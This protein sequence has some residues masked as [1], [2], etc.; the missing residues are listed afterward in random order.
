MKKLFSLILVAAM[1]LTL[2]ACTK[3][4]EQPAQEPAEP[5]VTV[6]PE[7]EPSAEPAPAI[8]GMANPMTE[9]G[10]LDEINSFCGT[11]LCHPPVMGVIDEQFFTISG[12]EHPVAQYTF[13]LNGLKYTF[14]A[15]ATVSEDISGVYGTDGTVFD[16]DFPGETEFAASGTMKLARW[17]NINGQYVL[18]LDDPE[19]VMDQ[20]TFEMVVDE[21]S[22]LTAG[23]P[24]ESENAAYFA[25]LEGFYVDTTS[26]RATAEISG[27]SADGAVITVHWG[28]SAFECTEWTMT[29]SRS[30]DG[31]LIYKD[32][33]CNNIE[34]ATDGTQTI[35]EVYADG[36]GFF[37]ENSGILYWNGAADENCVDCVFEKSE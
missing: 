20:E 34:T 25:G 37:G 1:L 21:L 3:R 2:A 31:L 33:V 15:C 36:S 5:E 7:Q 22:H 4:E 19:N 29:L 17:M 16:H 8:A 10:S 28:S 14:R 6:E 27:S 18:I 30:E 35:T 12:G 23:L 26:K 32:C 11:A 24:T 9:Y 13:D